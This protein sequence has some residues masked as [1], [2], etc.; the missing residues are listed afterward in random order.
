MVEKVILN[1]S[2][3]QYL[4]ICVLEAAYAYTYSSQ[5][6]QDVDLRFD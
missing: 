3:F 2:L 5:N 6:S 4:K 1:F